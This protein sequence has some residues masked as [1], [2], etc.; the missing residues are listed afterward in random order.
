MR[1]PSRLGTKPAQRQM[2]S[3]MRSVPAPV[4]GLNA[5]DPL[6][7]MKATDA[8]SMT[9]WFPRTGDCVIRGGAED[10]VT[11]IS[12]TVESIFSYIPTGSAN[13]LFAA[14]TNG[15]IYDISV[16]GAVGAAVDTGTNGRY[17]S[18]QMGVSGGHFLLLANGVDDVKSYNGTVWANPAL[19][20]VTSDR[21]ISLNVFK[22]RL[23]LIETGA[24][25]FWYLAVDSVAGAATEFLLGPLCKKGGYLMAMGNWTVDSGDGPDDYAVFV[26]S[27]GEVIVYAGTNPGS[28]SEWAIVGVYYIAPPIGRRCLFKLGGELLILTQM[29]VFP[30][31]QWLRS[32][33][34]D[35]SIALTDK[36]RNAFTDAANNYRSNFGWDITLLPLQNALVFN[37]PEG[38]TSSQYVMNTITKSWCSF[39]GWD[40]KCFFEYQGELYFGAST[41][42]VKAWSGPSDFGN[43]IV[44]PCQTAYY[45]FQN[46]QQNKQFKFVRPHFLL[47][48]NLAF[49][50]GLSM[51]FSPDPELAEASYST[52]GIALW[53]TALWDVDLW[54]Y[55]LQVKSDWQNVTAWIGACAST[56]LQVATKVVEVQ[57]VSTDY[58]YE[59]VVG[60][61]L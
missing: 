33:T 53:D 1:M 14:G 34:I 46:R 9:N 51:D 8:V 60:T 57:W 39:T 7:N 12:D 21:V 5:R 29:G 6:A 55:G 10:H 41:K 36:I 43:N 24:L 30:L 25:S 44:A 28:A 58:L 18:V 11:D 13:E 4:G 23:F 48:G 38:D 37:V 19:T 31:S 42:V 15:N 17:Q 32:A 59:E 54:G 2:I 35:R 47:N 26:T 45:Y 16:A 40:A 49:S 22:R 20:G 61:V 50:V 56:H 52:P 3:V 27:E